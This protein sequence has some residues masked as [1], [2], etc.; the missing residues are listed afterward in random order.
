MTGSEVLHGTPSTLRVPLRV[1][2]SARPSNRA[3]HHPPHSPS[4]DS[5]SSDSVSVGECVIH[6]C[7][8]MCAG[9]S[10]LDEPECPCPLCPWYHR[11]ERRLR[12]YFGMPCGTWSHFAQ[13]VVCTCLAVRAKTHGY[14]RMTASN[15]ARRIRVDVGAWAPWETEWCRATVVRVVVPAFAPPGLIPPCQVSTTAPGCLPGDRPS[16]HF[17]APRVP[18][19]PCHCPR[20]RHAPATVSR[21]LH[22]LQC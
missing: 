10:V 9:A 11:S 3:I 8:R 1:L 17:F 2:H 14:A 22:T 7:S 4:R 21:A 5:L 20:H 16:L 12:S 6:N 18:P 19:P 13:N 15:C